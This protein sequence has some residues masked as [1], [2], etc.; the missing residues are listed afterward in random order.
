VRTL[1]EV[2]GLLL[3]G[4]VLSAIGL[5][6]SGNASP[7][8]YL[9]LAD[10]VRRQPRMIA[11]DAERVRGA[12]DGGLLVVDARPAAAFAEGHPAGAL[13]MPFAERHERL[14]ELPAGRVV[15]SVL[16]VG[17]ADRPE[18]ARE[19]A[20]WLANLWGL[21]RV[22]WFPAGWKGWRAAGLP[23]AER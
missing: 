7:Q 22:G 5:L 4:A 17:S 16:V 19:L 8:I 3:A 15:E 9:A 11:W 14:A 21:E 18:E 13:S 1:R 6:V 12:E 20:R 10:T 2:A 23:E